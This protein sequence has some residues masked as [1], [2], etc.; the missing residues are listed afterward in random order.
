MKICVVGAGSIGGMLGVRLALAGEDVT[1]IA[2]GP[3]LEAIRR[4]GLKLV[5]HDGTQQ[6]ARNVKATSSMAETGVQD[7]VILSHRPTIEVRLN[8][9]R[10]CDRAGA[11]LV[12]LLSSTDGATA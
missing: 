12:P 9:G 7:V 4:N 8:R 2:R 5:S 3:H 1:L 11:W 10:E 6:I